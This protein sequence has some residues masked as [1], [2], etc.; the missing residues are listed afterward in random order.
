MFFAINNTTLY[1][2]QAY[3]SRTGDFL[4]RKEKVKMPVE[5]RYTF[6]CSSEPLCKGHTIILYPLKEA[7]R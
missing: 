6:I 3:F 1:D 2:D 5:L 7:S 4:V